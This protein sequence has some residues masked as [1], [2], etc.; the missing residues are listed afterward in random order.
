MK[1]F[2]AKLP[3]DQK[4]GA[5]RL[6]SGYTDFSHM[7]NE[8]H[9]AEIVGM[10]QIR[11]WEKNVATVGIAASYMAREVTKP[12]QDNMDLVAEAD[13][14]MKENAELWKNRW[15]NTCET[16]DIPILLLMQPIAG[17]GNKSFEYKFLE[18]DNSLD[19]GGYGLY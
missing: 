18:C 14:M 4:P 17:I 1:Q 11:D 16:Y 9:E 6:L 3:K 15:D 8:E 10:G 2:V 5:Q 12:L 7:R 13:D 19:I